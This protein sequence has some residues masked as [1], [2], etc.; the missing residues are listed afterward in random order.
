MQE[1]LQQENRFYVKNIHYGNYVKEIALPLNS[2]MANLRNL[3][4]IKNN[5]K[6]KK[7]LF[8]NSVRAKSNFIRKIYHNFGNS[9]NLSFL[10]LTYALNEF[11]VKKCKK[12]LAKFF[13]NIKYW[14]VTNKLKDIKY[15]YTYEYQKRG[16][17]HFHI[18]IDEKLPNKV[19]LANWKY[20]INKNLK[21]K[22]NT[23]EFVAQYCSKYITANYISK[24]LSNENSKNQFD[25]NL[26]SYQFSYNCKNPEIKKYVSFVSLKDI[27]AKAK[28]A[29]FIRFIK[30]KIAKVA[31]LSGSIYDFKADDYQLF[32][33]SM[34]WSLFEF[35]EFKGF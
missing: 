31:K 16:A 1:E 20:G 28:N 33:K 18:L 7:K 23:Q 34:P 4:G 14:M 26:K 15:A 5:G 21:V 19:V 30:Q 2:Y 32:A 8:H 9:K 22:A 10:T 3:L 25:L 24:N 17:L 35:K 11:D 12:D 13:K 6:N 27:V 29:T